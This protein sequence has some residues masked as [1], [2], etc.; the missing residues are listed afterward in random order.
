[1]VMITRILYGMSRMGQLPKA[2]GEVNPRTRTPLTATSFVTLVILVLCLSLGVTELADVVSSV[3]LIVF[4]LVNLSL[5]RLHALGPQ[6]P[7]TFAVPRWVPPLGFVTS[8]MFVIFE[9]G[10]RFTEHG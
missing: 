9:L 2:L 10:R 8:M 6:P 5:W 4:A 7:D 3:T 1:M